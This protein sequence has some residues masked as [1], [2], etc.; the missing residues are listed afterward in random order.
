MN[1]R[2]ALLSHAHHVAPKFRIA[3]RTHYLSVHDDSF[4]S[5]LFFRVKGADCTP[6]FIG[7]YDVIAHLMSL[8]LQYDASLEKLDDLLTGAPICSIRA[9]VGAPSAETLSQLTGFDW[10]A[11]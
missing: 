10:S 1:Q 5:K 9:S 8:A 7:L 6:E 4:S 11:S 3:G 2:L